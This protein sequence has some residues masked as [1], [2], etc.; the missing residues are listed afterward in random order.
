M[1]V[2]NKC[3]AY[4]SD[5][6][7]LC[8]DCNELLGKKL[9]K[10]EE[11]QMRESI[12]EKMEKIY[13]SK[14]PLYV[15]G[16]DKA[17]GIISLAGLFMC[18]I[19][20]VIDMLTSRSFDILYIG[21]IFFLLAS[22]EAFVP[23]IMWG[24]EK[25]RLS[26]FISDADNAQP[27]GFYKICRKAA[28]VISAAVGI[29]ALTINLIQFSHLPVRKYISDIAYTKSV[30][31][32]SNTKDYI[33]ANPDKWDKIISQDDYAVNLFISELEKAKT[34]GLEEQLMI[35]AVIEI[36]GKNIEYVNKDDFLFKYYSSTSAFEYSD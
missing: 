30:S 31:V 10:L 36:T 32:S 3:G 26:F 27:S 17:M 35:Q 16:F 9:S 4:N 20:I 22:V 11:Q 5:E 2:C 12:D 15:S 34:T 24:I 29:A 13:N 18:L 8:V 21:V 14:D 25:I 7:C 33:E 28:I 19:F 6:R 1:K 23:K